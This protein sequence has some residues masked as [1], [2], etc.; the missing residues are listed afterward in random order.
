MILITDE[1]SMVSSTLMDSIDKQCKAV[2]NPNPQ[3]AQG[4][5]LGQDWKNPDCNSTAVFG[6]L[7]VSLCSEICTNS[8]FAKA[9]WQKQ[10]SPSEI[11]G[12][13]IWH[14]F[15]DVGWTN[16]TAAGRSVPSVSTASQK[17]LPHAG[18]RRPI[19]YEGRDWTRIPTGSVR[20]L[21]CS[22]LDSTD[23]QARTACYSI[24]RVLIENFAHSRGQEIIVY[25]AR[26]TWWKKAK[27]ARDL[28]IDKLLEVQ[29]SSDVK[30]PGLLLYT[31]LTELKVER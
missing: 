21:H 17:R 26:H 27:G 16:E 11:R 22:C 15:K 13:Q 4:V 25:P 23:Q 14:M 20:C 28:D 6:S 10:E 18:R 19:K 8:P 31:P 24:N 29:D 5:L 3:Q 9:L 2:K 1:I 30:G 12:Q 7:P